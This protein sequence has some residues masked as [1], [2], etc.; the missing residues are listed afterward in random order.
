MNKCVPY[1]EIIF[2]YTT[3]SNQFIVKTGTLKVIT[4]N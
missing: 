2:M 1:L 4:L 3:E